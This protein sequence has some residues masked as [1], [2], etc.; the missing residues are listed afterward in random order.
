MAAQSLCRELRPGL[1][2]VSI[3]DLG[4]QLQDHARML[5]TRDNVRAPRDVAILLAHADRLIGIFGL[6]SIKPEVYR[7][8][9]RLNVLNARVLG[10]PS[11]RLCICPMSIL[12]LLRH[13]VIH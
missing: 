3:A 1:I 7:S 12:M 10:L 4:E 2:F 9:P 8:T 11:P 13:R 5:T 6:K